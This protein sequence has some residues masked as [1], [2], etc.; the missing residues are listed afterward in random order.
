MSTRTE[1]QAPGGGAREVTAEEGRLPG[2]WRSLTL[3]S[4]T[5][6]VVLLPEK[7]GEIYALRRV[8]RDGGDVDVLWKSPWGMRMP[9]VPAASGAESQVVW[10]DHYGG[11]WQDLFPNAGDACTV[12][13]APHPFH[14]EASVVPWAATVGEGQGGV[15]EVRLTVRLG[16]SPFRLEKRLRLDPDRPVL[17]LHE[18]ATNEGP[19]RQPY[20]WGQHPAFGAPFLAGGV[21]LDVP[22]AGYLAAERQV[23]GRARVASGARSA[24]PV[25]AAAGGGT[26]D[27]SVVPG[28]E[29]RCDALGFLTDLRAGWYALS[30][31][32][33]GLGFAL[34]WPL[35]VFPYVWLWQE[36][37]GT[38]SYP[39]YATAYVMGVEPHTSCPADGLAA[40][41]ARG[42]A[43]TLGPG[44]T[45][46]AE[47]T[48]VLFT[49]GGRVTA[50]SPDGTVAFD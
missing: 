44:E 43:R 7:G 39:W 11:G 16:R 13:G 15:P 45:I 27:L 3:R 46:A 24:W 10:L 19:D 1:G 41:V 47:V 5:L 8:G 37:C 30:N 2:G 32:A 31:D 26:V 9:P 29:A 28:P 25:V 22:A 6:E 35:D 49:P 14:G 48:A 33:L 23:S 18:Q 12:D 50:V 40:A 42:D 17:H 34:T 4:A 36:L 21:R 38:A 20:I